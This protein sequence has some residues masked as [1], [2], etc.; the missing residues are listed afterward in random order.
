MSM[1]EVTRIDRSCTD[2]STF[3]YLHSY[4]R[5]YI[6]KLREEFRLAEERLDRARKNFLMGVKEFEHYQDGKGVAGPVIE[7]PQSSP[8]PKWYRWAWLFAIVIATCM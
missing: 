3:R 1:N 4:S 2:T 6:D 5:V 8:W 7:V